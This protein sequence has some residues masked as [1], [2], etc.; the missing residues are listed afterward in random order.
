MFLTP[1]AKQKKLKKALNLP[2]VK[3]KFDITGSTI[4]YKN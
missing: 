1:P 3:I 4:I 2:E